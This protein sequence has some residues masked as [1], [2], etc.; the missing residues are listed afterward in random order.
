M[1]KI[2]AYTYVIQHWF[3]GEW[4][5]ESRCISYKEAKEELSLYRKEMNGSFRIAKEYDESGRIVK[6]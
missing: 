5:T 6:M 4:Y 1:S 2:K 3:E